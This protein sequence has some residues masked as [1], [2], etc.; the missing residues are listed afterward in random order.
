M[1]RNTDRLNSIGVKHALDCGGREE[2]GCEEA[3]AQQPFPC[4]IG[5]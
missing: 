5:N 3:H 1:Y 4:F 2:N